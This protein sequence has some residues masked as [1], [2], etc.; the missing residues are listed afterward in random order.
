M[1]NSE[2]R[3]RKIERA[4]CGRVRYKNW[5]DGFYTDAEK[6]IDRRG[7]R[8]KGNKHERKKKRKKQGNVSYVTSTSILVNP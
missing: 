3:R 4:I 2:E 1:I 5:V 7:N 8:K 6:V